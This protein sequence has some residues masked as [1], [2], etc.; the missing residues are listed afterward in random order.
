MDAG[1]DL[2][3]GIRAVGME[4]DA[5]AGDGVAATLQDQHHVIGGAAA[6][7]GQQHFPRARR[8]VGAAAVHGAVHHCH[9]AAAGAGGK[10]HAVGAAPV[11][12]AIHVVC[13]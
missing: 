3:V 1:E 13:P 11:D 10:E 2:R 8:Q 7:A 5:A 12:R 6:R 9:V 4:L